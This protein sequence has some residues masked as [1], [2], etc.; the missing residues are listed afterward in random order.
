MFGEANLHVGW[1][2]I[3]FGRTI[4]DPREGIFG[5]A[6]RGTRKGER[7]F[8]ILTDTRKIYLGDLNIFPR[9]PI[10]RSERKYHFAD[11]WRTGTHVGR[12]H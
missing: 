1:G 2:Y 3:S 10:S 5:R 8:F 11:L 12:G 9:A 7:I 6:R 4:R